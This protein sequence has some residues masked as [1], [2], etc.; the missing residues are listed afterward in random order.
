MKQY[1]LVAFNTIC[2]VYSLANALPLSG[3]E[4]QTKTYKETFSVKPDAVVDIN[5]SHA[6]LSFETWDQ[7][8]VQVEAVVE[9]E[10]AT[11]EE[12]RNYFEEGGIEILG[13]S[14]LVEIRTLATAPF[15]PMP[16]HAPLAI[17]IP[18]MP[19]ME[20]LFMDLRIPDLPPLPEIPPMPPVNVPSFDYKAY[21]KD[22]EKYLKKWKAEFDSKFDKEYREEMEAWSKQMAAEAEERNKH[23]EKWQEERE[24][25]QEEHASRQE[26][27]MEQRELSREQREMAREMAREAAR[28]SSNFRIGKGEDPHVFYRSSDG[29]GKNFR[30]KKTIKIKMPKSVKLKMNVRHGEVKLAEST[31]DMHA[32]LSYARLLATNIDGA[33]TMISASYSPVSVMRWNFGSLHTNFSEDVALEEVK[34]LDLKANSSSVTIERLLKKAHIEN[35]LGQLRINAVADSFETLEIL[36]KNGELYCEVP[37]SAY[38][39][40]YRG[41]FS[42]FT[43][44]AS[45]Q[46]QKATDNGQTTYKGYHLNS[47]SNRSIVINSQYSEV[48]LKQ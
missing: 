40:Q 45:L 2:L 36:V 17:D 23:L 25:L 7:D 29:A 41:T 39:L 28:E 38:D 37:A 34:N 12:A 9:L 1:L 15:P 32:T 20:P 8:Q 44:P 46:L 3:Q 14:S 21:Q 24:K 43:P 48:V 13:N 6:D 19:D 22:G 16:P 10:G 31:K 5:I 35:N 42:E 18:E 33:K 27:A 11:P 47:N 4:K 30:I 26:A